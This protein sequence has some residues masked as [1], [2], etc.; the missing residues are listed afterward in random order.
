MMMQKKIADAT[1]AEAVVRGMLENQYANKLKLLSFHKCWYSAAGK[2]E[3]W[4]VEGTLIRKK[5][6]LGS[7]ARNFRYQVDPDT[8]SII[9]YEI[10]IPGSRSD[11]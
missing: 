1:V 4:D 8:G 11:K 3:F 7:E 10:S 5:G 2:Q 6:I 9:G